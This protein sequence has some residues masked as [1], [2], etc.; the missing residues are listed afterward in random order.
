MTEYE[1]GYHDAQLQILAA[2]CK[3]HDIW[4]VTQL[5]EI[6]KF[7]GLSTEEIKK[8]ILDSNEKEKQKIYDEVSK[9]AVTKEELI[10]LLW[11]K[12]FL[13]DDFE[14]RGF[15]DEEVWKVIYKRN[16]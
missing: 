16:D 5:N 7:I 9:Q 8:I 1:K 12:G 11:R 2:Y 6:S 13:L 3:N 15:S 4:N 10:Y 14:K